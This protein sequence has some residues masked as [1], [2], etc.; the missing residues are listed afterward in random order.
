M[1]FSGDGAGYFWRPPVK[2]GSGWGQFVQ[3]TAAGDMDGDGH[4][5]LL[6]VDGKGRLFIYSGTGDGGQKSRVWVGSG[7]DQYVDVYGPGDLNG[8][9][10]GDVIARGSDGRL[11]FYDGRGDGSLAG[12]VQVGTGGWAQFSE[13]VP[14]GDFTG[15]GRVDVFARTVSGKLWRYQ[16]R[17]DGGLGGK[18]LIGAGW[19]MFTAVFSAG[20]TNGDGRPDLYGRTSGGGLYYYPGAGDGLARRQVVTTS[21]WNYPDLIGVR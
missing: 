18:V 11:W 3:V 5:D 9:G 6:A 12:R 14:V 8:N 16:A 20:D 1:M 19:D 10:T 4:N 21:G 7:W 15:N 17:G 13:L 2:I